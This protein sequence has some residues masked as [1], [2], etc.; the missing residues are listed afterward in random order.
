[1]LENINKMTD[2][3]MGHTSANIRSAIGA[4]AILLLFLL[5]RKIFTRYIFAFFLNLSS[6]SRFEL[7]DKLLLAFERP[8]RALLLLIGIYF[9]LRYLPL[10]QAIDVFVNKMLRSFIIVLI[11]WG[12]YDLAGNNSFL[13]DEMKEKLKIDSILIPWFTKITRFM[14]IALAIVLF[15]HEWNYDVNG[16]VAGLGLGGLAFALA[17]KDAL[18]NIF[19]GIVII[20]EKP[21]SIGDSVSTPS[22]E[23][24][25]EDISFR[26]TRF[27]NIAQALV[28]V[29]NSTL[30][31]EA[32]TNLSRMEKRRVSFYL[33]LNKV[34][35]LDQ[36]ESALQRIRNLIATHP[37]VHSDNITVA[38]ESFKESSLDIL[39]SYY[40][41]TTDW[42]EHLKI[43]EEINIKIMHILDDEN[44]PLALSVRPL[45][46]TSDSKVKE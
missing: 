35:S 12:L 20:M 1:M 8:L 7:N 5:L 21:F 31:N 33:G 38:F 19:G 29:P 46:L 13:S 15:A 44:V 39:I 41:K 17:A 30:A 40:T 22:V 25:V 4:V 28:T 34:S 42:N 2:I 36:L 43:K 37:E 11:A 10:N 26:S 27:R 3:F 32:I 45:L 16:F 23:G 24:T 14:I 6:H 9:A 18:A